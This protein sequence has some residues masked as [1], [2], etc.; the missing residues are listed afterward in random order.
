MSTIEYACVFVRV[1]EDRLVAAERFVLAFPS[2]FGNA[3]VRCHLAFRASSR[4]LGIR[5]ELKEAAFSPAKRDRLIFWSA[6][7]GGRSTA[8]APLSAE[9][10]QALHGHFEACEVTAS[11]APAE[12]A[13]AAAAFF[14]AA[15]A[16]ADRPRPTSDRLV[17]SMDVGGPGWEGVRYRPEQQVLQVAAPIG[18][19]AGDVVLLALRIPGADRPVPAHATV[20]EVIAPGAA[21]P[22]RA[23]G[24][25]LRLEE[26][27]AALLEALAKHTAVDPRK[28]T[29][30][31]PRFAVNAPVKVITP[32]P[33]GGAAPPGEMSASAAEVQ[34]PKPLA[35]IEY[36]TDQELAADFVENLSQG[37]AFVRTPS[38]APVGTPVAL[39]LK[40]PNGVDLRAQALVAFVNAHGMGVRFQLD[41]A[42]EA[43]LSTA[44]AHI[45]AR[46]RRALVV[47][48]DG[49][50]RRMMADA[51]TARGFEV[52]SAADASEGLRT[53]S[54]ELLALD[55]LVTDLRM[56][57]M[58]GED[59]VRT[60]RKTGGEADLAIVV[61]TGHLADGLESKL[62]AAGADAVLDKALGA[63]LVAQAADAV[64]ERKRMQRQPG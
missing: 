32:P 31:A 45:S 36:A 24:F 26:P 21:G 18:P 3:L 20:L 33:P 48:D 41:E 64:L 13:E 55:L 4:F 62:E 60:I 22:G 39:E 59:L 15:G 51:L 34:P 43:A 16:P 29:R 6:R 30:A 11:A 9:D 8:L 38:P 54:E 50:V 56:P 23:A 25:S 35:R 58:T 57:G 52:L 53:L 61:V 40:L 37:G 17:L 46:P 1:G 63:E 49:L 5:L 44:I 7:A 42:A 47:D 10:R 12:L 19:P 27:T 2:L 14:T 28:D